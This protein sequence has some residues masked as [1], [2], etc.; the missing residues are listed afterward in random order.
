MLRGQVA[1]VMA[2][3]AFHPVGLLGTS[4]TGN[5]TSAEA[6]VI[7]LPRDLAAGTLASLWRCAMPQMAATLSQPDAK[8]CCAMR[9]TI[10][11]A[12]C[13]I[14]LAG[15]RTRPELQWPAKVSGLW[16]ERMRDG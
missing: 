1:I 3:G 11:A 5:Q 2:P 15:S 7:D 4:P 13:D 6:S 12:L 8:L 14:Q 16:Q 10:T 9:L